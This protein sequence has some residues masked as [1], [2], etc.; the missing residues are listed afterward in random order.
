MKDYGTGIIRCKC[1]HA[2]RVGKNVRVTGSTS[3][4]RACPNC[5]K[6]LKILFKTFKPRGVFSAGVTAEKKRKGRERTNAHVLRLEAE[7]KALREKVRVG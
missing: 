2:M 6:M 5:G 4:R 7:N 1:S 3:A